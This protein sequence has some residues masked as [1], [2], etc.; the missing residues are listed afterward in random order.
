MTGIPSALMRALRDLNH[1]RVVRILLQSLGLTLL[2]FLLLGAGLFLLSR[3]ALR[4]YWGLGGMESDL[5]GAIIIVLLLL[6][7]WLLFRAVAIL[8]VGLFADA[9]I[10]DIETRHYPRAAA[11]AVGIGWRHGARLALASILR[12]IGGNLIALPGYIFLLVTGVGTAL[13]AL[14]VNAILLGRDLE[15]MIGARHPGQPGL[16]RGTR[17]SLGFLSA[18]SFMVPV[19]NLLAPLLS[20]AMTVHLFHMRQKGSS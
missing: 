4:E 14:A 2:I 20:A 16:D 13:L 7:G 5:A 19:V 1:P 9:L 3:W 11:S 15:A 17:W 18:A 12:L 6:G 8:V 10:D